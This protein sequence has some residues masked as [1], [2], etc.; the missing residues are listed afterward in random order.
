[1]KWQLM[2]GLT[3]LAFFA[4]SPVLDAGGDSSSRWVSYGLLFFNLD[5]L[6]KIEIDGDHVRVIRSDNTVL[7]DDSKTDADH[8]KSLRAAVDGSRNWVRVSKDRKENQE[9]YV[10]LDRVPLVMSFESQGVWGVGLMVSE[11][12]TIG[13]APSN[14]TSKKI[15]EYV[16]R[17][18]AK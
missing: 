6:L 4:T 8:L 3:T 5:E 12:T 1:M 14:E 17:G 2:L 11:G 18:L 9:W 15:M 13:V 7:L 16:G 10:N